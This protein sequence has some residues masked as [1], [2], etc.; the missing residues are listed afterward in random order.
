MAT[1]PPCIPGR[2]RRSRRTGSPRFGHHRSKRIR[3][4]IYLALILLTTALPLSA[5]PLKA[6][7]TVEVFFSPD[8]GATAAV[9]RELDAAR[10]EILVQAYSFTSRPIAKALVEAKKRG[11]KV[12][13]VLDKSQRREKFSSADFVAHAGIA[14]FI[15]SA[16]AIAHNKVIIVDRQTLITGSFNFTWAAEELIPPS[17]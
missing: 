10:S 11:V 6:T 5:E 14:T 12:E 9:V 2:P 7:G 16:H 1:R 13:V 8:G 4:L 17:V 3:R 15:D